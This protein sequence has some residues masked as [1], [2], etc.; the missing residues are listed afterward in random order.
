MILTIQYNSFYEMRRS[1]KNCAAKIFF[2]ETHLFTYTQHLHISSNHTLLEAV[3]VILSLGETQSIF[4][5]SSF[6][7]LETDLNSK[8][9]TFEASQTTNV[10]QVPKSLSTDLQ[11]IKQKKC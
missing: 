8:Y 2:G 4:S 5:I 11:I 7:S 1:F 3:I 10:N 6:A 9:A